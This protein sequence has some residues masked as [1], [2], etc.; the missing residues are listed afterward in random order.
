M[1]VLGEVVLSAGVCLLRGDLVRLWFISHH[2]NH[3]QLIK[4]KRELE[5]GSLCVHIKRHEQFTAFKG[6]KLKIR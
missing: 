5:L 1:L 6:T 3:L 2:R 4:R